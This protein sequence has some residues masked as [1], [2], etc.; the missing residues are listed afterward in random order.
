MAISPAM[1]SSTLIPFIF[2]HR[3]N[4]DFFFKYLLPVEIK[5]YVFYFHKKRVGGK[6]LFPPGNKPPFIKL[7]KMNTL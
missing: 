1:P 6:K 3:H 4:I 5:H 7:N 2:Q